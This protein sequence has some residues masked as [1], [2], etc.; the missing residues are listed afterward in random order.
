MPAAQ[1]AILYW[2]ASTIMWGKIVADTDAEIAALQQFYAKDPNTSVLLIDA[3]SARDDASCRAAIAQ[4]T[5]TPTPSDRCAVLDKNNS[6]VAVIKAD[7]T[8]VDA[9][10]VHDAGVTLMAHDL[11]DIGDRFN[12]ITQN[13]E[14]LVSIA[15]KTSRMVVSQSWMNVAAI[16]APTPDTMIA[17][18]AI[19]VGVAVP[20][21]S[22]SL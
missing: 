12:P 7:P 8:M 1:V 9:T 17:S 10:K 21:R 19:A 11:A 3:R 6:V 18:S 14:R 20:I 22:K 4:I 15:D 5:K 13:I 16:T 2:T